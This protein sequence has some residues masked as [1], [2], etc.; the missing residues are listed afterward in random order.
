V[1]NLDNNTGFAIL[2]E[3]NGRRFAINTL[4]T[5]GWLMYDGGNGTWN[6]GLFQRAGQVV[7]GG[8]AP[9]GKLTSYGGPL[10]GAYGE[11][12]SGTGIVGISTTNGWG[13]AGQALDGIGVYGFSTNSYGLYVG[14]GGP[15]QAVFAGAGNVGIGTAAPADKLHVT[16]DIRVGS[17]TTGCVKDADGTAIAGTCSSDRR[18]K[19]GITPFASSLDKVSRLQPVHFYWRA[20]EFP[21]RHF[22]ASE[23]FGLIAQDVESVLPELVTTDDKGYKAVRYNAL[24]LHMLQAIT[25]LKTE[26]DALKAQLAAQE[27]RLRRLE[28]AIAK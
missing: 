20:D 6:S 2:N 17:G 25:E 27:E 8:T 21:D 28:A 14:G 22:G 13:V 12:T 10:V 3:A 23:S 9:V 4:A 19:K 26:N 11:T 15:V 24:P 16:A 1:R 5:G 7:V 18:L